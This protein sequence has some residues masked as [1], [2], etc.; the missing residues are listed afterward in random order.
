MGSHIDFQ[1][2]PGSITFFVGLKAFVQS[3]YYVP[4]TILRAFI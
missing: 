2:H 3:A 1:K 4:G